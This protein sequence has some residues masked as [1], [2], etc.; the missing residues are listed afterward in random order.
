MEAL[1]RDYRFDFTLKEGQ[2]KEQWMQELLGSTE[3]RVETKWDRPSL[4]TGNLYVEYQDDPDAKGIWKPSGIATTEA[5]CWIFILGDPVLGFLGLPT[6]TV[7]G[8]ARDAYR[9]GRTS[10][11]PYGSCPTRGALVSL[12]AMFRTAR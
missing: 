11:Q 3:P 10:V 8:L 1:N 12:N 7:R 4:E 9:R 2:A 6:E 5:D